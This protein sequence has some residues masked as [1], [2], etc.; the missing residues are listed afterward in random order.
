MQNPLLLYLLH[1]LC[2]RIEKK[3]AA[4]ASAA[5]NQ[6]STFQFCYIIDVETG[7]FTSIFKAIK[8]CCAIIG[9]PLHSKNILE[10]H[11]LAFNPIF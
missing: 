10:A 7:G 4:F 9:K 6:L 3:I 11:Q 5:Q 1:Q 8:I 2:N